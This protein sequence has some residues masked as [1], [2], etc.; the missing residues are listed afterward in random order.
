MYYKDYVVDENK[1]DVG[2]RGLKGLSLNLD[3]LPSKRLK[4]HKH[5]WTL[6]HF[7]IENDF[8]ITAP[9]SRFNKFITHM[10]CLENLQN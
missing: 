1:E 9:V 6:N 10:I 4:I 2:E 7:S 3:A 8:Y 5:Q